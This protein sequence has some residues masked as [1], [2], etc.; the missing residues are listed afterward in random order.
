LKKHTFHNHYDAPCSLNYEQNVMFKCLFLVLQ[1]TTMA[2]FKHLQ[3]R[4]SS[5][6]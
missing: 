2:F 1:R 5:G 3:G 6:E 4:N